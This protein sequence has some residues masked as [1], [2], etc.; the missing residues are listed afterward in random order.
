MGSPMVR[1]VEAKAALIFVY[2][3]VGSA[4]CC[5]LWLLKLEKI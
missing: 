4:I 3:F 2:N 5:A 1:S